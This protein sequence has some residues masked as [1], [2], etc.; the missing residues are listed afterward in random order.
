MKASLVPAALAASLVVVVHLAIVSAQGSGGRPPAAAPTIPNGTNVAVIDIGY[1]F[2]NHNGFN[3]GI[4]QINTRGEELGGWVNQQ[5]R[6]LT[7]MRDKL[8]TY[9]AGSPEYAKMEEEITKKA[10]ENDLQLRRDQQD[11]LNAEAKLYYDT[12]MEIEQAIAAFAQR[13]RIGLVLRFNSE[14]VKPDDRGSVLQYINRP[15]VYHHRLD[16]TKDILRELN[17]GTT[18]PAQPS[19][20]GAAPRVSSQPPIPRP[21]TGT[22]KTR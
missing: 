19:A 22:N 13:A 6:E 7:T 16:I 8:K 18:P 2:K 21:G 12:Y 20:G 5:K 15:V 17:I 14:P 10:A 9:A 4:K 3:A 11:L 1:I